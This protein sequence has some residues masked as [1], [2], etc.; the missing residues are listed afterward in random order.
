MIK[1]RAISAGLPPISDQQAQDIMNSNGGGDEGQVDNYFSQQ[2]TQQTATKNYQAAQG[3]AISTLQS[4][5]TSLGDQYNTLLQDV[6]GQGT[7]AMNTVT[8][9]ENNLLGQR[10]ITNSSPLYSQQMSQA[11]LPVTAQN[12]AAVGSLG[13]TEGQLQ[14]GIAGNIANIQSGA[15][16]TLAELPLQYGSLAMAQ[17]ANV[18]NINLAG[19]QAEQAK[20]GA[21]FVSTPFGLYNIATKEFV[22]GVGNNQ[23]VVQNGVPYLNVP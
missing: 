11:Q 9:G 21:N 6:L 14:T 5:G 19:A 23:I 4:A 1:D 22:S 2:A 8:T 18:A 7:V 3:S 12:Q 13:Y 20:T 17:A 10:G 16:G 15:G